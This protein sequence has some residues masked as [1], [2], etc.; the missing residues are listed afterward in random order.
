MELDRLGGNTAKKVNSFK[1]GVRGKLWAPGLVVPEQELSGVGLTVGRA[2]TGGLLNMKH[3]YIV[4]DPK[5]GRFR[6]ETVGGRPDL[7]D[8]PSLTKAKRAIRAWLPAFRAT[9]YGVGKYARC[10]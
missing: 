6:W 3:V 7:N 9:V 1:P 10:A 8:Y 2:R 5:V 4:F